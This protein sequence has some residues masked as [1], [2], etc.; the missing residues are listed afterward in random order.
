MAAPGAQ[1]QRRRRP[2][3]AR[4]AARSASPGGHTH[5]VGAKPS[6]ARTASADWRRPV[7]DSPTPICRLLPQVALSRGRRRRRR[8]RQTSEGLTGARRA[9]RAR[10]A[11]AFRGSVVR[12]CVPLGRCSL[13]SSPKLS[14]ATPPDASG[15]RRDPGHADQ[16]SGCR[17]RVSPVLSERSSPGDAGEAAA[18]V[19]AIQEFVANGGRLPWSAPPECCIAGADVQ[20]WPCRSAWLLAF[21]RRSLGAAGHAGWRFSLGDSASDEL[22]GAAETR[23]SAQRRWDGWRPP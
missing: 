15:D 14:G 1:R 3:W 23:T 13:S 10:R 19:L 9:G 21:R 12:I 16:R 22:L 6:D 17:A 11:I 4:A 7:S 8:R 5:R 2:K 18:L 20:P